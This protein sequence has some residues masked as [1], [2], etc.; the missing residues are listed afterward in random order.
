MKRKMIDSLS[1]SPFCE[2]VGE[3]KRKKRKQQ[4]T[5]SH[6][7]F[8]SVLGLQ[9]HRTSAVRWFSVLGF[10]RWKCPQRTATDKWFNIVLHLPAQIP[11]DYPLHVSSNSSQV[12]LWLSLLQL[13]CQGSILARLVNIGATLSGWASFIPRYHSWQAMLRCSTAAVAIHTELDTGCVWEAWQALIHERVRDD[14]SGGPTLWDHIPSHRQPGKLWK[15]VCVCAAVNKS[16]CFCT[17]H[18]YITHII[19]LLW[20]CRILT[21]TVWPPCKE[22]FF[23]PAA[24]QRVRAN[25]NLLLLHLLGIWIKILMNTWAESLFA[26]F[27]SSL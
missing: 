2:W 27:E 1:T 15:C 25:I 21:V 20:R 5:I 13:P 18:S 12:V 9:W 22:V 8:G 26:L 10:P 19:L 4:P 11:Q 14:P 3:K 6:L 23:S 7:C 17:L 16:L 24:L